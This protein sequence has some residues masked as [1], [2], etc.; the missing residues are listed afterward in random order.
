MKV[1][2][3]KKKSVYKM[4][5]LMLTAAVTSTTFGFDS[6][7][8]AANDKEEDFIKT[9]VTYNDEKTQANVKF[10]IDS[11]DKE[12]Y[13]VTSIISDKEGTVIYDKTKVTEEN[14]PVAYE[15]TEN[16]SYKFTVKYVEKQKEEIK[17]IEETE[18]KTNIK[19]ETIT[20]TEEVADESNKDTA[21]K[22]VEEQKETES[23]N[24]LE[25]KS[26][27]AIVET[28]EN[29]KDIENSIIKEEK[30]N[31]EVSGIK[32]FEV[33][34]ST[35]NESEQNEEYSDFNEVFPNEK[36]E[37][38]TTSVKAGSSESV[39]L[40]NSFNFSGQ[41]SD[42]DGNRYST[43]DTS[44][45][46]ISGNTV[47]LGKYDTTNVRQSIALTSKYSIDFNRDFE[48]AGEANI[49]SLAD[50]F[51]VGFHTNPSYV[52][53]NAGGSLGVY[54]EP[55]YPHA[56]NVGIP[57]GIV[58]EVD[59]W[60]NHSGINKYPFGDDPVSFPVG[61]GDKHLGINATDSNGKV[62]ADRA[63]K[64]NISSIFNK[65]QPFSIKWD[66]N[67]EIIQ[68][69]IGSET[70]KSSPRNS[71]ILKN[72]KVYYT[73]GSVLCLESGRYTEKNTIK[74]NSFKYLDFDSNISTSAKV[75]SGKD[76]AIPGE[77]VTITHEIWNGKQSSE[78]IKDVLNLKNIKIDGTG[79]N[80][81]ISNIKRGTD[82]NN[83]T[84]V[85]TSTKF[86]SN[87]PLAVKYPA[88]KGKYY[89]QY[90]VS[91]PELEKYGNLSK[92]NCEVLLGQKGMSQ[93]SSSK[94]ID[95]KNKP[96]LYTKKNSSQITNSDIVKVSSPT[97]VTKELIW[98]ELY[99]K[100]ALASSSEY[101]I[102][103]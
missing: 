26:D 85:S 75:E 80:L 43:I 20:V 95:I 69:N 4:F 22:A 88:N 27:K 101:K 8:R 63:M 86:D 102:N 83:L 78:E 7:V 82:L 9:S 72:S 68:F 17:D 5:A 11:I 74:L 38:S 61:S 19:E 44:Y 16:G 18:I 77:K 55:E 47:S 21:S 90:D 62:Y 94:T 54:Y 32:K 73:I 66:S 29:K 79:S 98:S 71:H 25:V 103:V 84:P 50:G 58:V 70:I 59:T 87:N 93:I 81:E 89:V 39:N 40:E 6:I 41:K 3:L 12:K 23:E 36:K 92:L 15:T 24:V 30:I 57:N 46:N 96:A 49:S 64:H 48:I 100:V 34:D 31:V 56:T 52:N 45:Y 13:E 35:Q 91:I 60:N 65:M 1:K 97:E 28:V 2:K 67:N 33:I 14:K 53:K 10:E 76:H 42:Y 37:I 51:A 99:S